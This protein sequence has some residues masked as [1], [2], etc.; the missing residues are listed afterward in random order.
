MCIEGMNK[1]LAPPNRRFDGKVKNTIFLSNHRF[2][3]EQT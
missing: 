2:G 3:S 1:K